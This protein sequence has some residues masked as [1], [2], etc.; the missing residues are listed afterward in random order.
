M[1]AVVVTACGRLGVVSERAGFLAMTREV[2]GD[3]RGAFVVSGS[4]RRATARAL[5]LGVVA[6]DFLGEDAA[7]ND[8]VCEA[9]GVSTPFAG[10][11]MS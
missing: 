6:A 5:G 1:F 4:A 11:A 3:K 10:S 8:G 9:R 7:G 2:S